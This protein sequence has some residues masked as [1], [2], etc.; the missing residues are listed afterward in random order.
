MCT[1]G[2]KFT[3]IRPRTAAVARIKRN[4]PTAGINK[5][6]IATAVVVTE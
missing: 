1:R 6:D 5:F 2:M 4:S 3:H